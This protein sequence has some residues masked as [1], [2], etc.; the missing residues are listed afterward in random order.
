[1]LKDLKYRVCAI[2]GKYHAII[3]LSFLRTYSM[4]F[5][6]QMD[7]MLNGNFKKYM[8]FILRLATYFFAF[9][10]IFFILYWLVTKKKVLD[11]VIDRQRT[12]KVASWKDYFIFAAAWLPSLIIKY[13]GAMCWDTWRMLY[14]FRVGRI[15]TQHSV[16]YT[17]C[18][19]HLVDFFERIGCPNKGLW[20]FVFLQYVLTVFVFGYSVQILR[21]LCVNEK[22]IHLIIVLWIANPYLIG[23][24]GVAIK[25]YPYAVCLFLLT[26]LLI[27]MF[28][29]GEEFCERKSKLLLLCLA[30]MGSCLI[31]KNGFYLTAVLSIILLVYA[32]RRKIKNMLAATVI[33]GFLFAG[34]V[35]YAL[36]EYYNVA[37][38]SVGEALSLPFQQTARYV[39]Y[40][41][42][43]VT[44]EEREIIDRVLDYDTL[45]DSY[46]PNIADPIKNNYKRDE[47]ALPA[48]F[49]VW[50]RHFLRHPICYLQATWEQSYYLFVPEASANNIVFYQD[51]DVGY[52]LG[53]E[54]V[55]SER[56]GYYE[57]IFKTPDVLTD[58]QQW[59][60]S[61]YNLLHQLPVINVIGNISY[62]IYL[63]ICLIGVMVV[64]KRNWL[65]IF[66]PAIVTV[67]FVILG[68]AIQG[69]PRYVF[70][71][72]YSAPVLLAYVCY[73]N[74]Q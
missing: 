70:P 48:Y 41:G 7:G 63:L 56:T 13:P 38:S 59:I 66:L 11:K 40:Y 45:A 1:M 25:D 4:F 49:R 57:P 43:D 60:I 18:M 64:K 8:V 62:Y 51:T 53:R 24:Q 35:S 3:I 14:E 68:P 50:F 42:D 6:M 67:A 17:V 21:K 26:L 61:E 73:I 39:K 69:H 31:R 58:W 46:W 55:I 22:M 33:C 20:M 28:L 5:Y 74:G 32:I 10:A 36:G 9:E 54:I 72:V 47:S 15:T 29:N 34:L 16:F 2:D 30:V 23:Y 44:M 19:G 12:G 52:E 71:I 37:G 65:P 27:E